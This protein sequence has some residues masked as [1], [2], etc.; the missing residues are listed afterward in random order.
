MSIIESRK[1]KDTLKVTLLNNFDILTRYKIE[2]RTT[3]EI[4]NLEIDFSNCKILDSEA[5]IFMYHW[6]K[7][8]KTLKLINPPDILFE[9]LEILELSDI[10]QLNYTITETKS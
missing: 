3:K 6:D 8:G 4:E 2:S 5:V 7:S 9:I 1:S 10:W